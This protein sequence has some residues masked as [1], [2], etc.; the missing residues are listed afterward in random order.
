MA[1]LLRVQAF[2]RYERIQKAQTVEG[3]AEVRLSP[4]GRHPNTGPGICLLRSDA[5][6][7]RRA[8]F[9]SCCCNQAQP[10]VTV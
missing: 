4:G 6:P 3:E 7:Y 9:V 8:S 10:L 5:P 2:S 1:V